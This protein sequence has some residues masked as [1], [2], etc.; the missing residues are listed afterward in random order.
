MLPRPYTY[1]YIR[2]H[3]DVG[4]APEL[5]R[6]EHCSD[7]V[8]V[9]SFG[10]CLWE[11]LTCEV[12]YH[13]VEEP[14]VVYGVGIQSLHLPIPTGAPDGFTV[15]LRL[16][17]NTNPKHRPEFRQILIHLDILAADPSFAQLPHDTYQQTQDGWRQEIAGKF[18][19][20]KQQSQVC[21]KCWLKQEPH[22]G[23]SEPHLTAKRERSSMIHRTDR[24]EVERDES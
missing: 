16:C 14:A 7:Q 6:N 21:A 10:V 12:P 5:I 9:W 1:V 23:T 13:G 3:A 19:V 2:T 11:L 15:L 22:P 17:W 4:M 18:E 20:M 8:D 24:V